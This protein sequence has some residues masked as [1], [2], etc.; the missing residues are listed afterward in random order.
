M[1]APLIPIVLNGIR[2]LIPKASKEMLKRMAQSKGPQAALE[3]AKK[4]GR[5]ASG[6][7]GRT[8][9][10]AY[11]NKAGEVIAPSRKPKQI[12][13]VKVKGILGRKKPTVTGGRKPGQTASQKTGVSK[14]ASPSQAKAGEAMAK[15]G[16]RAALNRKL[17]RA[18]VGGA[19]TVAALDA[20]ENTKASKASKASN[21]AKTKN[22]LDKER[23]SQQAKTEKSKPK[24]K[25]F[26]EAFAEAR[27]EKGAGKTFMWNGKKYTTDRAD[28][29]PKAS[30]ATL[31]AKPAVPSNG[32]KVDAPKS[33]SNGKRDKFL[34]ME[35]DKFT[36]T[37]KQGNKLDPKERRLFGIGPKYKPMKREESDKKRGGK[38]AVKR[39]IG[40][41]I[42][43]KAGCKRGMGKAQRGY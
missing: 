43:R 3:A 34:S 27:K 35:I 19:T 21:D 14:K 9:G 12:E 15:S 26:N 13:P 39:K 36:E 8:K 30:N 40:G 42:K 18:G 22:I 23:S 7:A 32:K 25:T 11:R 16:N 2:M 31:R 38:V 37:D 6:A 4:V 33:E 5:Q 41:S 17:K 1:A 29:K 24:G 28:D 20:Y 10:G